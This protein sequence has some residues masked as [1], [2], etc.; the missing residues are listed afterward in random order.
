[1]HVGSNKSYF[2]G[3]KPLF[4]ITSRKLSVKISN[5]LVNFKLQ[6]DHLKISI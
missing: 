1:M 4:K 3:Y 2:I 5:K 6:V